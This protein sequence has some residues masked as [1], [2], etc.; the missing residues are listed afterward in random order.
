MIGFYGSI[1]I[2]FLTLVL[3]PILYIQDVS[4]ESD[5]QSAPVC[6]SKVTNACRW[7]LA[8]KVSNLYT[9][10]G[11]QPQFDVAVGGKAVTVTRESGSYVPHNGDSVQLEV[12]RG[13]PVRVTGP[14]GAAMTTDQYPQAKLQTDKDV[15]GLFIVGGV[16]FL[17]AAVAIGWF[18]RGMVFARFRGLSRP[19]LLVEIVIVV[20][21]V[22]ILTPAVLFGQAQ[23]W[24]PQGRTG[25]YVV[26]LPLALLIVLGAIIYRRVRRRS[27]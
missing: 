24:L 4:S 22:L 8:S 25:G 14:D 2:V 26:G 15:L 6:G 13:D 5:Y 11:D 1:A 19:Q 17:G 21:V 10:P 27:L 7:V 18:A 3:Y 20:V 9:S 12:W 16:F 23:G